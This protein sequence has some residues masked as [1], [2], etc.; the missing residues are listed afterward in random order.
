M[1]DTV[2]NPYATATIL[3]KERH[4]EFFPSDGNIEKL[5]GYVLTRNLPVSVDN[6]TLAY[7]ALSDA[8][9]LDTID[10]SSIRDLD[11]RTI[12]FPDHVLTVFN[13]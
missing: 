5:V 10:D 12:F 8:G 7:T 6:F 11:P 13:A 3:F 1:N 2:T 4:P 9:Q